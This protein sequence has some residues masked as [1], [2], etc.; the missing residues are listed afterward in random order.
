MFSSINEICEEFSIDFDNETLEYTNDIISIFNG[1][2]QL[3]TD[4]PILLRIIG[5]YYK[6]VE[7]NQD[8]MIEYYTQASDL[9]D[10]KAINELGTHYYFGKKDIDKMKQIFNKGVELNDSNSMKDLGYYYQYDEMN[11]EEMEKYYLMAIELGNIDAMNNLADYYHF[12]KK[13]YVKMKKYYLMSIELNNEISMYNLGRYYQYIEK[14]YY[15]MK[16]YYL[17][18]I[19]N[20]KAFININPSSKYS[21]QCIE[22]NFSISHTLNSLGC[23]YLEMEKNYEKMK[24]YFVEA[25]KLLNF[26]SLYNLGVY[27]QFIEKNYEEMKKFYILQNYKQLYYC[28]YYF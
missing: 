23:Y 20:K 24:Y 7:E 4:N 21:L 16:K 25:Y 12:V 28:K 27:Y 18:S 14:N 1:N 19:K 15:E 5:L 2:I 17:M 22:S 26:E 6:N 11:Y 8:K 13:D 3:K 9:N 10:I